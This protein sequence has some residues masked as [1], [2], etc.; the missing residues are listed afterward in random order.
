MKLIIYPSE[1]IRILINIQR[2]SDSSRI[3]DLT[4]EDLAEIGVGLTDE[5]ASRRFDVD[6]GDRGNDYE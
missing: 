3:K 1:V 5:L 4:M 2:D 6:Q